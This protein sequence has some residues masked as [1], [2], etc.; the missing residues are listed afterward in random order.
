MSAAQSRLAQLLVAEMETRVLPPL[1]SFQEDIVTNFLTPLHPPGNRAVPDR[2]S[3][4]GVVDGSDEVIETSE[5]VESFRK[6]FY[7]MPG[8]AYAY[9]FK[10]LITCPP[11]FPSLE[12]HHANSLMIRLENHKPQFD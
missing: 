9:D 6:L 12:A 7:S 4:T 2:L 11:P 1:N 3:M 10:L 8:S 5:E